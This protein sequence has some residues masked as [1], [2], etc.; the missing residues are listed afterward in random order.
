MSI[1]RIVCCISVIC[2]TVDAFIQEQSVDEHDTNFTTLMLVFL[3]IVRAVCSTVT[4][5]KRAVLTFLLILRGL[6]I[7]PVGILLNYKEEDFFLIYLL[8]VLAQGIRFRGYSIPECQK[9]LPKAPGGEEPLP[10]G[11]FWL[12]VT[13]QVP[14]EEQVIQGEE[15]GSVNKCLRFLSVCVFVAP[16]VFGEI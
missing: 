12:L 9:L 13:G 8:C 10:E 11:L 4:S 7:L 5:V 16:R 6:F 3:V 14:S 1:L 15:N 2:L